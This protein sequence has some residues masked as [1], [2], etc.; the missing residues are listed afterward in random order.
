MPPLRRPA[1]PLP[2]LVP[3]LLLF[4][5]LVVLVPARADEDAIEVVLVQHSH[6]DR[7]GI[8]QMQPRGMDEDLLG[9]MDGDLL[10]KMDG[11]LL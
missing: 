2:L 8:Q 4:L 9:K 1:V 10:E 7:T 5:L 6:C 3:L 11:D